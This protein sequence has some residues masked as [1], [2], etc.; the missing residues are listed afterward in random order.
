MTASGFGN[1]VLD[2]LAA[3]DREA[4]APFLRRVDL[5]L[6]QT[7]ILQ[8]APVETVHFPAGAQ[9]ANVVQLEDGR[10]VETAVVG[11]EGVSGLAP[12]MARSPCDWCVS[13]RAPG[14][15]W[16]IKADALR[17]RSLI[18]PPLM[19]QLLRLSNFYQTQAAQTAAC[20]ALH[21]IHPRVARWLLTADDLSDGSALY[22]TQEELAAM[23]G[24]RRTSINDAMGALKAAK[25]VRYSRGVIKSLDR[26]ALE[27]Q[28]CECYQVLRD[29]MRDVMRHPRAG[30][31]G[32]G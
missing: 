9:F 4:L 29:R 31:R 8:G 19:D 11:M 7:L 5:Q 23:L 13:V 6:G 32:E 27:A 25:T 14:G 16:A 10:R 28:A 26:P 3:E 17:R 12:F 20:N 2:D 18:S 30:E 21:E 22:F 15:A 24:V 1:A